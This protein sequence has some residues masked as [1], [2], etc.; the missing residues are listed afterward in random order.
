MTDQRNTKFTNKEK[1]IFYLKMIITFIN[2][3]FSIVRISNF[4]RFVM[5]YEHS[6]S[7]IK[8]AQNALFNT[9]IPS[10]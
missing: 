4:K 5:I 1:T 8:V 2:D 9:I 3:N 6:F 10:Y 7:P